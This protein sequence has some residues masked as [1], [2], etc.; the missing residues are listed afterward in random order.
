MRI[1]EH[2]RSEKQETIPSAKEHLK[3]L[4]YN[5]NACTDQDVV[6]PVI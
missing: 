3:I 6:R 2:S 5:A 1:H 4:K